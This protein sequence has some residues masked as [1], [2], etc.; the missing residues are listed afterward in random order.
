MARALVY[1]PWRGA[2]FS[3]DDFRG[4]CGLAGRIIGDLAG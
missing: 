2:F 3:F 4:W 1:A